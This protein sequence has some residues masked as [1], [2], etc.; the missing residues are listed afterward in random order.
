MTGLRF[1]S[2]MGPEYKD[3]SIVSDC[4]GAQIACDAG[5]MWTNFAASP[6]FFQDTVKW[7]SKCDRRIRKEE[8][9]MAIRLHADILT[10]SQADSRMDDDPTLD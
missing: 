4:C 6:Y 9:L 1:R 7:C 2:L 10:R 8:V 3:E 5:R